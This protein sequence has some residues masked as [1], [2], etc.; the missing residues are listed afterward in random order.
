METASAKEMNDFTLRFVIFFALAV[1][2]GLTVVA[3]EKVPDADAK[4]ISSANYK[5]PQA[6]IDAE[7]DGKVIFAVHVDKTGK[8]TKAVL[9]SGLIWPCGTTPV[10]EIEELSKVLTDSILQSTFSPAINDGKPVAK[11]LGL[12]FTLK[13]PKL[14]P[15]PP[16][17]DPATGTPL[18][19]YIS[20]GVLNGRA[21]SLRQPAYPDEAKSE[22]ASGIVV[23]EIH[24]DET[25]KIVR[26]G[27]IEGHPL[28]QNAAREAACSARFN[29]TLL[30]GRPVNVIGTLTYNFRP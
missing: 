30:N 14:K 15:S 19:K 2:G 8:P 24:I 9:V 10:K 11:D 18:P 21:K 6:A 25:G 12:S 23:V 13:N 5:M 27:T 4:L 26:A 1:L 29:P 22:R 16:E 20:A 7:I 17:M 28:L 3:Q